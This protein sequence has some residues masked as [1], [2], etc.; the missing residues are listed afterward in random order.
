[1]SASR[2]VQASRSSALRECQAR[3]SQLQPVSPEHIHWF[4]SRAYPLILL[5]SISTDSAPEHIHWF[6]SRAYPLILLQSIS[7]DSAPEHIHWFCSR[8]YPLILL[9]SISTDSAPEHIHWFWV[10]VK[11]SDTKWLTH[12]RKQDSYMFSYDMPTFCLVPFV[13]LNVYE[14]C[15]LK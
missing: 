9:Q 1:M 8:A 3:T 10:W 5:Q 11:M 7:T 4:C 2:L 15:H 13:E 12:G 6:C 14:I